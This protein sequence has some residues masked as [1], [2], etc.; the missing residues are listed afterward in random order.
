MTK[1]EKQEYLNKN[2]VGYWSCLAGGGCNKVS[3]PAVKK[4]LLGWPVPFK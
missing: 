4:Y 1:A 3:P 2:S